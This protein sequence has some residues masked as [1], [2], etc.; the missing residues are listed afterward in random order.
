M[1]KGDDLGILRLIRIVFPD[2]RH[3][4]VAE[5]NR[6]AEEVDDF[7]KGIGHLIALCILFTLYTASCLQRQQ[8]GIAQEWR[9]KRDGANDLNRGSKSK[10]VAAAR[11][12]LETEG[13][14][15]AGL[16]A[17][18]RAAGV[19]HMAPYRHFADKDALLAAV[20]EQ[21]FR[22]LADC[23]E[24]CG[25]SAAARTGI[26][27]AYVCFALDN[28][29][30]YRLMF[31]AN[32]VPRDRFPELMA[33]GAEAFDRCLVAAGAPAR[34]QD[35]PTDDAPAAAVA[36]WSLVHELANLV[37]DGLVAMPGNEPT[38]A[39]RIAEILEEMGQERSM[40]P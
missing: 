35:R 36:L 8:G 2:A 9:N 12:L 6:D 33:A 17:A 20:A 24:K 29:A 23:M 31:G 10:L 26:G 19:S 14:E 4:D 3:D 38:R 5:E 1:R 21:G 39:R 18:A 32:L 37:L 11:R 30:L 34:L 22:E 27:V 7:E 13:V 15:A 25:R 40:S 28:P 16:R